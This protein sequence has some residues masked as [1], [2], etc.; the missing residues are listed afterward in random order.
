MRC[1][2]IVHGAI[3]CS[4]W[5]ICRFAVAVLIGLPLLAVPRHSQ[6]TQ[7][8]VAPDLQRAQ[9]AL[10]S[11]SIEDAI[12]IAERYVARER[13]DPMGFLVLGDAYARR[14]PAGR[15]R[16]LEAYRN[17]QRIAPADPE[18]PYRMAQ[19]GLW[20]GGADGERIARESLERVL[21]IDAHY[22]DAWS[23]WLTVYRNSGGRRKM[24]ARLAQQRDH[25]LIRAR[26]A[27]LLIEDESYTAA[28]RL[29][30]SALAVDPTNVAWLALRAQSAF[31][32]ADSG[33]GMT[34]YRRALANAEH[35]STD[36]LWR[37]VIGIAMPAEIAAWWGRIPS[38][39][40]GGWLESFWA[41]RSPN[42]FAGVNARIAE[43]FARLRHARKRFPLLHPLIHYH[44]DA[45][46]RTLE[47]QPSQAERALH[48]RCEVGVF[49][50][51]PTNAG[52]VIPGISRAGDGA[53]ASGALAYLTDEERQHISTTL[54]LGGRVSPSVTAALKEEGPFALAP[55][56]FAPLGLDLRNV[57]SIASRVGYNLA[58]GLDDRGLM[59]LRFG[60][61]EK[62]VIGADNT[63]DPAC[64][65]TEL[66]RWRYP[67]W[68]EVRFSRPSAFS[69]GLR[70]TPEMVFRPMNGEQFET[71]KLGLTRDAPSE[72]APLEFGVWTAHF[73][74]ADPRLADV[75]VFTTRGEA[76]GALVA[77]VGGARGGPS[78]AGYV[79]LPA[80]PGRYVLLVHAR[81]ADT[82]GRQTLAARVRD[83][84]LGPGVSDLV[85]SSPW[86]TTA[87]D[88]A[89]MLRHTRRDLTF[90]A[91]ETVRVYAELYGLTRSGNELAYHATYRLLKSGEPARD[92]VREEWPAAVTFE[93]DR[94]RRADTT[95]VEIETLDIDPQHLAPGTYLLRLEIRDNIAGRSLG[96]STIALTV[97]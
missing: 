29:L 57:D 1:T 75:V 76:A 87:M 93:F 60:P 70:T 39:H 46:G 22:R 86:A 68:G 12:R 35:D 84:G 91:G 27:Q 48:L 21:E 36:A 40:K 32:A 69:K 63:V 16:A 96:R 11:G 30:D 49:A 47:L 92:I 80:K 54:R 23:L 25:P 20:L 10:D 42:L 2:W 88:R 65:T 89:E 15:F 38:E 6:A 67:G 50:M 90:R 66:E 74:N 34:F 26:I 7:Q 79:T 85:V 17:A 9:A 8:P 53:A 45:R 59:F 56:I 24:V 55:G 94:A 43:H 37:Q 44:R 33:V 77:D 14:M 5:V 58:T 73:R 97:R 78:L 4:G 95:A 52:A 81:V 28:D 51:A 31:E 64:A 19:M 72:P 41:R 3:C 13:R 61:P 82:L 18:P 71:M 62:L 83:F